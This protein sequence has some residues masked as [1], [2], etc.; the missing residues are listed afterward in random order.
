M[1]MGRFGSAIGVGDKQ[2]DLYPTVGS[3]SMTVFMLLRV[4]PVVQSSWPR[5]AMRGASRMPRL[6]MLCFERNW[7]ASACYHYYERFLSV[8]TN[9]HFELVSSYYYY[10]SII[11]LA[12]T[13]L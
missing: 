3:F 10:I 9:L 7:S 13:T 12:C 11:E 1:E 2:S 4:Q 5:Q 6:R 8:Q